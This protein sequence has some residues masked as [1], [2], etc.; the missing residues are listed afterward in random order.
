MGR[1]GAEWEERQETQG[2]GDQ[3]NAW[4]PSDPELR[5]ASVSSTWSDNQ[6]L[7]PLGARVPVISGHLKC[8]C[9]GND[10]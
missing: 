10:L 4:Q 7:S 8:R 3:G 5:S 6:I 2:P 1:E 9:K